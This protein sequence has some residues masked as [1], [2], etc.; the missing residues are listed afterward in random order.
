MQGILG[1]LAGLLAAAVLAGC[2]PA[3]EA[4]DAQPSYAVAN[5]E[6][7]F[8]IRDYGAQVVAQ[9]TTR[10]SYRQAVEQGYIRLERYFTG[11]N[12]VPAAIPMG[13][14]VMVRDDGAAGWTTMF[15]LPEEYRAETAPRPVDQRIRVVELPPRRVA[16][17]KFPGE[18]SESLLREQAGRLDAWLA[19]RGLA[20]RGDFRQ[21]RPGLEAGRLALERGAR[22]P[23]LR[24]RARLSQSPS[25]ISSVS[26]RPVGPAT[27][28]STA[29]AWRGA[30]SRCSP[31]RPR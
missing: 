10:G 24:G 18:L 17:V 27:S 29:A 19:A 31:C 14:P 22:H 2:V 9:H 4:R 25:P 8:E 20:H 26:S 13:G 3:N 11:E 12:T 6:D 5:A 1:A 15:V 28:P 7:G 21:P 30:A 23:A 16:A